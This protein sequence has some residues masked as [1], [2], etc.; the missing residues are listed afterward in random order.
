M[1]Q[2]IAIPQDNDKQRQMVLFVP[3]LVKWSPRQYMVGFV[4]Q[5]V[6]RFVRIRDVAGQMHTEYKEKVVYVKQEQVDIG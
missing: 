1:V 3:R 2:G 6:G 4:T 5:Q